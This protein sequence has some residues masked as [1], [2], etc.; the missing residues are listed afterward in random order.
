MTQPNQSE[1][2]RKIDEIL[3]RYLD[4]QW[5]GNMR[6]EILDWPNKQIEEVLD[7]L[8]RQGTA[9]IGLMGD[10]YI[11]LSALQAERAKLKEVK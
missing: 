7:R 8:A 3:D 9:G 11:P 4:S 2:D 10:T 5:N 1:L 6:N